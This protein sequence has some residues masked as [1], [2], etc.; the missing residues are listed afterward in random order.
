V[1]RRRDSAVRKIKSKELGI[2]L[3]NKEKRMKQILSI[4]I[5]FLALILLARYTFTEECIYRTSCDEASKPASIGGSSCGSCLEAFVDGE[6][7]GFSAD[8]SVSSEGLKIVKQGDYE[9][10]VQL[11]GEEIYL[12]HAADVRIHKSYRDID[13][14]NIDILYEY[15]G[16]NICLA[17]TYRVIGWCPDGTHFVS[18]KF[19]NCKGPQIQHEGKKLTL[20]FESYVGRQSGTTYPA[21]T[22]EYVNGVLQKVETPSIK[23]PAKKAVKKVPA[24][25]EAVKKE[26]SKKTP[27][28]RPEKKKVVRKRKTVPEKIP[29]LEKIFQATRDETAKLVFVGGSACCNCVVDS[30]GSLPDDFPATE[31]NSV[32]F[33]LLASRA[34]S[35]YDRIQVGETRLKLILGNSQVEAET[36]E[37]S[38]ETMDPVRHKWYVRFNFDP[39]VSVGPGI[40]WKLLDGDGTWKS[41]AIAHTS[42]RVSGGLPGKYITKNCQYARTEDAWYSVKF[43]FSEAQ[44]A[45]SPLSASASVSKTSGNAPL[46]LDFT[47][48]ATGG[49]PPYTYY[50]DFGDGST[51]SSQNPFHI[52]STAGNYNVSLTVTD[53]QNNESSSSLAIISTTPESQYQ[54]SVDISVFDPGGKYL[55]KRPN[56]R[57]G[58]DTEENLPSE[59]NLVIEIF[60]ADGAQIPEGRK[61]IEFESNA[62]GGAMRAIPTVT[63]GPLS[64]PPHHYRLSL[65]END[66]KDPALNPGDHLIW[67]QDAEHCNFSNTQVNIHGN[68]YYGVEECKGSGN[69]DF[70]FNDH[71]AFRHKGNDDFTFVSG[72]IR[73]AGPE[74]EKAYILVKV[75]K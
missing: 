52:Y 61:S 67:S 8:E 35:V 2:N 6:L 22:W 24:K 31:V 55:F 70:N 59:F 16:G 28:E 43:D 64:R 41:A 34:N 51:S 60:D 65:W 38:S 42:S 39:P 21:E 73:N 3:A 56:E 54:V 10:S 30:V 12:S 11:N 20:S 72:V 40:E 69:L 7:D 49:T 57:E 25:K 37:L 14:M 75:S 50:W 71:Y 44:P 5:L 1:D 58:W 9:F 68:N 47:G 33:Y 4:N 18:E 15:S 48:S 53:S 32:T 66:N 17:F 36:Q 26:V 19:G 63:I 74:Y 27:I 62:R 29:V 23:Q 46:S 45:P 13:G